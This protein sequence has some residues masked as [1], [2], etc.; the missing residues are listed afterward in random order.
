MKKNFPWQLLEINVSRVIQ[1]KDSLQ[2]DS[3]VRYSHWTHPGQELPEV[4]NDALPK[5]TN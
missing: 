2:P 1:G 3:L 4:G 5:S